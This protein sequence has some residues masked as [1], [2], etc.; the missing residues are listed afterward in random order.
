VIWDS[1]SY[2]KLTETFMQFYC[3]YYLEKVW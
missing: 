3:I 1:I 2:E